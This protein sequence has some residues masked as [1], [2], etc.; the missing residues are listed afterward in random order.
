MILGIS[1]KLGS[2]KS[3]ITKL[4]LAADPRYQHKSF[5]SKLKIITHIMTGLPIDDMYSQEGKNKYLPE[6]GMTVGTFQQLIGTNAIRNG[7]HQQAWVISL[8]AEYKKEDFWVIDDVRFKNEA[9]A[10]KERDGILLRV[11]GDPAG[12]RANSKR[13]LTHPSET[14]LDDYVGWDGVYD[15]VGTLQNLET[16]AKL[17]LAKWA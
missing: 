15:N 3:T 13:D 14:D 7:I 8:F 6:W 11:N 17:I 12:T 16:Y 1:G 10:I 4:I 9:D 5:A 2:G